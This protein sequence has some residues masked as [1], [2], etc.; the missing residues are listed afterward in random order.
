MAG[1]CCLNYPISS[2]MH[3]YHF[4][5]QG[6]CL[7]RLNRTPYGN[8]TMSWLP[9]LY[10]GALSFGQTFPLNHVI[11]FNSIY[12]S[13]CIPKSSNVL[14]LTRH[15]FAYLTQLP[16]KK[17]C[18]THILIIALLVINCRINLA[19]GILVWC[20]LYVFVY[21]ISVTSIWSTV[22][23]AVPPHSRVENLYRNIKTLFSHMWI[24]I[25][26]ALKENCVTPPTPRQTS[27]RKQ[28]HVNFWC[29]I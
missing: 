23:L 8:L 25:S 19:S 1:F 18:H 14:W 2:F 13:F 17:F 12:A 21:V 20:F 11:R 27:N 9:F 29:F 26:F 28:Y 15:S 16:K 6:F 10:L 24:K 5:F 7:P 4:F 22:L 3:I